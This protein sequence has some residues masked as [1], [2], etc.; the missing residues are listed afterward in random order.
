MRDVTSGVVPRQRSKD[1]VVRAHG[2]ETLVLDRRND[3]VHCLPAEVSRVWGACTGGSSLAEVASAAGTDEQTAAAAIDQLMLLDLLDGPSCCN[4]RRFL[5]R[6][7]VIGAGVAAVPAIDSV[8]ASP[9]WASGSPTMQITGFSCSGD[10]GIV[11]SPITVRM[12]GFNPGTYTISTR[13]GP[14]PAPSRIAGQSY[15]VPPFTATLPAANLNLLLQ[16][17]PPQTFRGLVP[18][19]D[20]AHPN[21][22]TATPITVVVTDPTGAVVGVFTSTVGPCP[23]SITYCTVEDLVDFNVTSACTGTPATQAQ[24]T[25]I[26]TGGLPNHAYTITATSLSGVTYTH[27]LNTDASGNFT[28]SANFGANNAFNDD[29]IVTVTLQDHTTGQI[30]RTVP[31]NVGPCPPIPANLQFHVTSA[32]TGGANNQATLTYTLTGGVPGLPY[33]YTATSSRPPVVTYSNHQT[34][35]NVT[36]DFTAT[37]N[38]GGTNAFNASDTVYVTLRQNSATGA[39]VTTIPVT[40]GPCP[41]TPPNLQFTVTPSC[42]TAGHTNQAMLAFTVTGGAP[43]FPYYIDATSSRAPV[44]TYH[45]NHNTDASGNWTV[46]ATN[47]GTAGAFTTADTVTVNLRMASATGLIVKTVT[48]Q[49]GPCV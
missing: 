3:T 26:A 38:F 32:C 37:A 47:F 36:G 45:T 5:Q 39:I 25:Y 31:V 29:D 30:L 33:Y 42:G 35:N 48:V 28:F 41:P 13:I 1:L 19:L 4:R 7:A 12:A 18:G 16:G 49:V 21:V 44:V 22:N 20:S 8:I 2:E 14:A 10:H 40:V 43:N 34:A 17:N 11:K 24:L 6:S 46:A 23:C 27:S 15:N 9:A